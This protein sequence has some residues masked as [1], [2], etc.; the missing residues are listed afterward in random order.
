M[1]SRGTIIL[2]P[3]C[4][5]GNPTVDNNKCRIVSGKKGSNTVKH[6]CPGQLACQ[7]EGIGASDTRCLSKPERMM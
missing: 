4:L 6:L 5:G 7:V 1:G 3:S 2:T